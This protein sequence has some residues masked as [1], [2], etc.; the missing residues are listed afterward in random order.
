MRLSHSMVEVLIEVVF[1]SL[2]FISFFRLYGESGGIVGR[3]WRRMD[4]FIDMAMA[5]SFIR[6]EIASRIVEPTFTS[7]STTYISYRG[8]SD[9]RIKTITYRI[10]KRDGLYTIYRH[11]SG[12]GNNVVYRPKKPIWFEIKGRLVVLHIEGYEFYIHEPI[13]LDY[14]SDFP[15][16]SRGL[17][18]SRGR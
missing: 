5:V 17:L 16:A 18:P 11:A 2:A 4:S 9:G 3:L 12:E 14:L 13:R 8:F 1:V 6:D 7:S 10:V 15:G